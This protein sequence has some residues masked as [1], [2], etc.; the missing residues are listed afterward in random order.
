MAIA[1]PGIDAAASSSVIRK[2]DRRQVDRRIAFGGSRRGGPED[3]AGWPEQ[4][5][6]PAGR[7]SSGNAPGG[8]FGG[9]PSER[10]PEVA[11]HR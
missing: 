5:P 6:R 10:L 2:V 8:R 4:E 9:W 11:G 7:P 1:A 3:A